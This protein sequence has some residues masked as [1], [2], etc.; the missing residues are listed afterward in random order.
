MDPQISLVLVTG[1]TGFIGAH[2]VDELLRRGIKVRATTRS[3]AKAQQM[4]RDRPEHASNLQL[5]VIKDLATPGVFDE[6][7][8]GV[9][10]VIHIASPLIQGETDNERKVLIPAIEGTK[11]VF[12]AAKKHPSVKRIVLTSSIVAT[13]DP[14][15]LSDGS[16][17]FTSK[18][19]SPITY[20]EAKEATDFFITYRGAKKFAELAAWDFM[21]KEAPHFDL[22]TICPSVCFGP[23]VHPVSKTSELNFTT[24]IL[25]DVVAARGT[26]PLPDF[27]L[28]AYVDVRDVAL[29][30]V[31]A[32]LR[33][34]AG[35][36]RFIISSP[37]K[38]SGQ[39]LA[40]ILRKEF[41]WAREEIPKGDEGAPV[42]EEAG[43]E[44]QTG[45]RVLGIRY[46]S[47]QTSVLETA[48]QLRE[49]HQ[50]EGLAS[51]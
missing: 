43:F 42:P 39:L 3:L 2:V 16:V 37:E 6:E 40:D 1:A 20:E 51:A 29:A 28:R 7:I 41:S 21:Q 14:D 32:L 30:H 8:Q 15:R 38:F 19:W 27:E 47:L 26:D 23:V 31:E 46:R 13:L 45:A 18:D 36:Q 5:H 33:S 12:E 11:S 24:S 10:G 50:K 9:D 44:G 17:T 34:E 49:L 22:V 25:W 48:P 35:G 4:L